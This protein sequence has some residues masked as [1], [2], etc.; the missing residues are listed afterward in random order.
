MIREVVEGVFKIMVKNLGDELI[1]YDGV[2]WWWMGDGKFEGMCM[3]VKS[4]V[5]GGLKLVGLQ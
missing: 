1:W 3:E 5:N 4:E 2:R